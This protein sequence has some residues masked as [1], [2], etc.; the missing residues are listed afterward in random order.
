MPAR[1]SSSRRRSVSAGRRSTSPLTRPP[2]T[3]F[4][5]ELV[6]SAAAARR[7]EPRAAVAVHAA[8]PRLVGDAVGRA[9]DRNLA[10]ELIRVT[11]AAHRAAARHASRG[12]EKR[13]DQATVSP[14]LLIA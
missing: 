10:L 1:S 4:T 11:E 14:L 5:G 6:G 8:F 12:D 2:L 7:E 13:G 3:T 9:A